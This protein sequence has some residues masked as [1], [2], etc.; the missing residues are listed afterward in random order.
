MWFF[1]GLFDATLIYFFALF[2]WGTDGIAHSGRA[3]G[4]TVMGISVAIAALC[5]VLSRMALAIQTWNPLLL[6]GFVFS[7]VSFGGVLCLENWALHWYVFECSSSSVEICRRFPEQY[8]TLTQVFAPAPVL[9]IAVTFVVCAGSE[10]FIPVLRRVCRPDK[11]H[12]LL[13]HYRAMQ[14]RGLALFPSEYDTV[15]LNA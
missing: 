14:K 4:L 8:G 10:L 12:I 5:V 11:R 15:P 6:F 9:Y 1:R 7:A 3:A 13:E 2:T